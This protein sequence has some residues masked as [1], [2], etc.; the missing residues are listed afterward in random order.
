MR[1]CVCVRW[2]LYGLYKFSTSCSYRWCIVRFSIILC[3]FCT[4]FQTKRHSEPN[5]ILLNYNIERNREWEKRKKKERHIQVP[6]Q[7]GLLKK[8]DKNLFQIF[9]ISSFQ[10]HRRPP[11]SLP[12][13]DETEKLQIDLRRSNWLWKL[14]LNCYP[15]SHLFAQKWTAW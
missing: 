3:M 8:K 15:N 2:Y 14:F 4:A 11:S 13:F 6:F 9:E 12:F 10:L 7:L 5:G 1:V